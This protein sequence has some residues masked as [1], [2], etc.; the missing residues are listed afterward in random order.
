[1]SGQARQCGCF[2]VSAGIRDQ[3]PALPRDTLLVEVEVENLFVDTSRAEQTALMMSVLVSANVA[4]KA[5]NQKRFE[6]AGPPGSYAAWIDAQND[7]IDQ[8]LSNAFPHLS[9]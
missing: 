6:Y 9:A 4:G 1:M 2:L 8:S 7:F 5:R 3:D